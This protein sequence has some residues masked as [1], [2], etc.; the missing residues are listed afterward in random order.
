MSRAHLIEELESIGLTEAEIAEVEIWMAGDSCMPPDPT[1]YKL[2]DHYSHEMPYG[3]MKGRTGD[4][5]EWVF[6]RLDAVE[7]HRFGVGS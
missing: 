1:W 7:A 6:N 3:T 4:P 5:S 2:Y